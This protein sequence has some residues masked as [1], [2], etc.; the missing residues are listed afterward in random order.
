MENKKY[1]NRVADKQ[2]EHYLDLF[3]AVVIEGAKYC[4]KTWA[5][6][7]FSKSEVVLAEKDG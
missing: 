5:G 2:I 1:L 4:G 7:R 6:R 3:G